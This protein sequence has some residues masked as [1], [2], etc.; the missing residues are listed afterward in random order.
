MDNAFAAVDDVAAL[1]RLCDQLGAEQIDA[2]MRKWL[3]RLPHPFSA[4]DRAAGYRYE[5]SILQ[6]E[7]ALTQMLDKPVAGRVFFEQVI[8]G[9]P[10]VRRT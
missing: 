5:L 1:Q 8:R 7:F 9:C 4:A 6:A 2:L 10:V 3:R